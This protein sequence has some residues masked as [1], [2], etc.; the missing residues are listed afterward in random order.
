[1]SK[2]HQQTPEIYEITRDIN[3]IPKGFYRLH[4]REAAEGLTFYIG[5]NDTIYFS[6]WNFSKQDVR[7]VSFQENEHRL[8]AV[9][10][11]VR[12]YWKLFSSLQSK[13]PSFDPRIPFTSCAMPWCYHASGPGEGLH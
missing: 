3:A 7:K 9:S 8:T 1:M 11:F 13:P 5:V 12:R 6:V 4:R 2:K 10:Q